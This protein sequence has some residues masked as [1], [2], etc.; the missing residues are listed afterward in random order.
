M[1]GMVFA[2][3]GLDFT[4]GGIALALDNRDAPRLCDLVFSRF[5]AA[6][7]TRGASNPS[8][9]LI[10]FLMQAAFPSARCT[11]I[12]ASKDRTI[13]ESSQDNSDGA[14]DDAGC[15]SFVSAVIMPVS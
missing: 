5:A 8:L 2:M 7:H 13:A 14:E 4:T 1:Y 6:I 9:A 15:C 11:G 10:G 12:V 3:S